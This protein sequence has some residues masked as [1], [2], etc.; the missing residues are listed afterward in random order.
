MY[1]GVSLWLR[2]DGTDHNLGTISTR[3]G[4]LTH[5]QKLKAVAAAGNWVKT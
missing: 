1:D 4:G 2:V 5:E 3:K